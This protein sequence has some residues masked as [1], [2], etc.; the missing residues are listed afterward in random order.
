MA[1]LGLAKLM[2]IV[3]DGTLLTVLA[4][5]RSPQYRHAR[6][7]RQALAIRFDLLAKD[8]AG[9]FFGSTISAR[10]S[11]ASNS[12]LPGNVPSGTEP[13]NVSSLSASSD[14]ITIFGLVFI[15]TLFVA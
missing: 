10:A 12:A 4:G 6:V 11:S 14:E 15:F 7:L 5:I 1:L 8:R 2:P 3:T 13:N 9:R